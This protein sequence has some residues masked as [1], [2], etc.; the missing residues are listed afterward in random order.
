VKR[1]ITALTLAVFAFP[2]GALAVPPHFPTRGWDA[3][4]PDERTQPGIAKRLPATGTDVAA[5]DQQSPVGESVLAPASTGSDFD[6]GDAGI[7]AGSA[8]CLAAAS[9]GSAMAFRRRR[10]RQTSMA[11]G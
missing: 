1:L 2:A 5:P 8:I 10:V 9:L 3:P 11:A 4:A 6:W 7:G